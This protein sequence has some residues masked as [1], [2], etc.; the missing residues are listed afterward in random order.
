MHTRGFTLI[1]LLVVIAIIGIMTSIVLVAVGNARQKGNDAGILSNLDSIRTQA[2]VY[3]TNNG[4]NYGV[5]ANVAVA[6]NTSCGSAAGSI[7][8][9]PTIVAATKA[10]ASNAGLA[11]LNGSASADRAAVCGST[12]SI[13]FIAVPLKADSTNAWCVDSLGK[14]KSVPITAF[15]TALEITNLNYACP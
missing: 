15:D 5:Q 3:A 8:I 9:D 4:N 7:W 11:T 6:A 13:W 12:N 1:E 2:E 10:A 14:A